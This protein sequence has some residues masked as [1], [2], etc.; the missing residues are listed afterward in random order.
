MGCSIG[1]V[2]VADIIA[3]DG[4]VGSRGEVRLTYK[5]DVNMT[6]E[7]YFIFML[8]QPVCIPLCNSYYS[9]VFNGVCLLA[10]SACLG[11]CCFAV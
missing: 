10:L 8:V 1:V 7:F 2:G 9:V 5:K 6:E 3:G 4:K 11:S